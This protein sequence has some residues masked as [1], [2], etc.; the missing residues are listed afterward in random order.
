[1]AR[2]RRPKAGASSVDTVRTAALRLSFVRF[3]SA[4][5]RFFGL[6]VFAPGVSPCVETAK[7]AFWQVE[8]DFYQHMSVL[9]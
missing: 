3:L 8:N 5:V 9:C 4:I 7:M 2:E 6:S 1:M